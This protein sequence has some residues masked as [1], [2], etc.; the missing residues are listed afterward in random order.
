[1]SVAYKVYL[2]GPTVASNPIVACATEEYRKS[3]KIRRL[4]RTTEP[5]FLVSS[6]ID[7]EDG[8]IV[9]IMYYKGQHVKICDSDSILQKLF[10]K[11]SNSTHLN[12]YF[13]L[14]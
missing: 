2:V 12:Q 10:K 9:S 11:C 14:A 4:V 1:M 5:R 13:I 7:Q 3:G 8:S 6:M